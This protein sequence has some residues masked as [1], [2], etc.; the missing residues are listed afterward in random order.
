MVW[1]WLGLVDTIEQ[2]GVPFLVEKETAWANNTSH[3]NTHPTGDVLSWVVWVFKVSAEFWATEWADV[4]AFECSSWGPWLS[5]DTA[6]GFAVKTL[7]ASFAKFQGEWETSL[8]E[9]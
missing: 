2:T 3:S 9:S 6:V 4:W 8:A 7:V 1:I 5:G